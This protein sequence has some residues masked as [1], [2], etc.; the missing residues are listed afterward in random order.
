MESY[1]TYF[2]TRKALVFIIE[3]IFSQFL[4][5]DMPNFSPLD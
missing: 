1:F 5:W 2:T 3:F 4:V